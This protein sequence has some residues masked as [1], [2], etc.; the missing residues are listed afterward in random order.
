LQLLAHGAEGRLC[1]WV[2]FMNTC[3]QEFSV[4]AK[5]LSSDDIASRVYDDNEAIIG[6]YTVERTSM[7]THTTI[8]PLTELTAP[9]DP[10][11]FQAAETPTA[12]CPAYENK[13]HSRNSQI[14]YPC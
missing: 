2:E 14:A 6:F 7:T 8:E 5:D 12:H 13:C 3:R 9:Y 1:Y 10:P 4:S 11:F